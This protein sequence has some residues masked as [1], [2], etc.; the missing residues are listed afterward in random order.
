MR[1]QLGPE[2]TRCGTVL[3]IWRSFKQPMNAEPK[4]NRIRETTTFGRFVDQKRTTK[5]RVPIAILLSRMQLAVVYS[6]SRGIM[7]SGRT[8]SLVTQELEQVQDKPSKIDCR[9]QLCRSLYVP[10]GQ[11]AK[12]LNSK[13]AHAHTGGLS[14]P[15]NASISLQARL[16]PSH[17]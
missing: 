2:S 3:N 6:S 15:W 10:I 16:A 4:N 11:V 14:Y 7:R 13:V 8:L 17:C 12:R 9:G 5:P 1:R